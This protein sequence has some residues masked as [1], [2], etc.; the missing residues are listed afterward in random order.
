M[1]TQTPAPSH[2]DTSGRANDLGRIGAES[3]GIPVNPEPHGLPSCR[4]RP[5]VRKRTFQSA[6][7]WQSWQGIL[8]SEALEK[9]HGHAADLVPD[10]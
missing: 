8:N 7:I 4:D 5:L 3:L 9:K 2:L 6:S 1:L 10:G